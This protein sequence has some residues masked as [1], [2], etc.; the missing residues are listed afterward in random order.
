MLPARHDDDEDDGYVYIHQVIPKTPK[1]V[2]DASLLNTQH[3]KVRIKDKEKRPSL[4]LEIVAIEKEAFGSPSITVG[5]LT[6]TY[7]KDCISF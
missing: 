7:I 6:Y 3:F 4:N 2:F 5:Q 1:M